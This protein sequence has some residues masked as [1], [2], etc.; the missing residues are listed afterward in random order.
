MEFAKT[1]FSASKQQHI[2]QPQPR[3]FAS[4]DGAFGPAAWGCA[5]GRFDFTLLFQQSIFAIIP[6]ILL[7][8]ATPIRIAQL[9]GRAR[10]VFA[11]S[12]LYTKLVRRSFSC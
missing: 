4:C 2:L 5:N 7:L 8:L 10:Q 6:S 9:K 11:S 12:F 1:G 3:G